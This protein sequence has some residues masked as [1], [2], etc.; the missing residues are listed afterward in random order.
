MEELR[1]HNFELEQ[2]VDKFNLFI[3]VYR[4]EFLITVL[5]MLF[6]VQ[7]FLCNSALDISAGPLARQSEKCVGPAATTFDL[8]LG[9]YAWRTY[10]LLFR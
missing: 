7:V 5:L 2:E 4:K 9:S 8:V 3:Y 10:S 1:K 6:N